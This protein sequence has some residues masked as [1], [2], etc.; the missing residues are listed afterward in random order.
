MNSN[1]QQPSGS[2]DS[3][4][5]L[6]SVSVIIPARNAEATI[7][8]TL[9]SVMAQDYE[10]PLEVIVAD[11]SDTPATSE[12]VRGTYP[13]VRL[14]PNPERRLGHG[15]NAAIRAATGDVIVRC[16]AHTIFPSGYVRQAVETLEETG[17]ANVGGRQ[18]A[19]GITFFERTVA[20]AMTTPLGVG[21]SRHRLGG[22]AG[23]IDTAFLGTFRRETLEELGGYANLARNQDYELNYRLRKRGHTVWF[24]PELVVQ[25]RPR[26][27]LRALA[28]QYFNYGR[29]KSAVLLQHPASVR[30]RH[31]AA[32]ALVLSLVAGAALAAGG[33]PWLAAGL[34]VAYI[35]VL[36]GGAVVVGI[37]RRD[38]TAVLLPLALATMHL[39]WGTGFFFRE[40]AQS[41]D[42]RAER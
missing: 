11:G 41:R 21:D 8:S 7:T 35:A 23:A 22:K 5:A 1:D 26:G 9:D 10:G 2:G 33:F 38:A 17:A 31:L 28:R 27:T 24:N 37:R 6:P 36:V 42:D 14:I 30:P 25:Y 4:A 12:V 3:P 20:M 13:E 15:A 16:D 34:L 29:G 40:R 19:V 39:C 32:P 18:Y